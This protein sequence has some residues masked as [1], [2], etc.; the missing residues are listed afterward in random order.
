MSSGRA[1]SRGWLRLSLGP[2]GPRQHRLP[3]VV[4]QG[5]QFR[6]TDR[7]KLQQDGWIPIVVGFREELGRLGLQHQIFL[8]E[9]GHAQCEDRWVRHARLFWLGALEPNPRVTLTLALAWNGKGE[10]TH[11]LFGAWQRHRDATNVRL[12]SHDLRGARSIEW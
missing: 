11:F 12:G 3:G 4:E 5:S 7:A 2:S 1:P 8:F 6:R 9:T 10:A